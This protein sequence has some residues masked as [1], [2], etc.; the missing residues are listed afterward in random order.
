VFGSWRLEVAWTFDFD[1]AIAMLDTIFDPKYWAAVP[2]HFWSVV[3]FVFGSMVGSFLNVCIHRMPLGES[4]V[5]PPSHC[6]HCKYPAAYLGLSRRQMP[7]LP[8]T[9][10]H[11]L[12]PGGAIDRDCLLLLLAH[13]RS[14]V[15]LAGFGLLHLPRGLDRSDIH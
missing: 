12:L 11:P 7:Q 3:F 4:I 8:R 5:S 1:F 9:H 13:V 6:P 10:F 15:G 2:F 14:C